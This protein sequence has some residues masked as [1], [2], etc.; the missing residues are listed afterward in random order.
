[1]NTNEYRIITL[2][3]CI[4]SVGLAPAVRIPPDWDTFPDTWVGQDALGRNMPTCSIVSPVRKDHR[5]IVGIFYVALHSDYLHTRQSPYAADVSRVLAADPTAPP[6]ACSAVARKRLEVATP[7]VRFP[8][9]YRPL[10]H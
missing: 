4:L 7:R 8:F 1:L 2:V 6:A 5:R 3:L 10:T 9:R